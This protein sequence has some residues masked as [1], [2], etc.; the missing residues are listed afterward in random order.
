MSNLGGMSDAAAFSVLGAAAFASVAL[1]AD[2]YLTM[3][4]LEHGFQESNPLLRYLFKKVGQSFTVFLSGG[5]VL[6]IGAAI[7]NYGAT[8]AIAFFG[9]IGAAETAQAFLNYRKLKKTKVNLK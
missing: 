9:V 8:P 6:I 4:G 5:V 2:A 7:T 3:K 1:L